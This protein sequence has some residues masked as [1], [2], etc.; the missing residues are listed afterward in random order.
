M[1]T[2]TAAMIMKWPPENRIGRTS[3]VT[4]IGTFMEPPST[5]RLSPKSPGRP[6]SIPANTWASPTVASVRMSRGTVKNRR[7]TSR[8]TAAPSRAAKARPAP[9]EAQ[10]DQCR[11]LA[12]S[13]V[14]VAAAEPMATWAKLMTRAAR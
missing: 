3:W 13:S 4:R 8:S 2:G 11:M 7:I 6:S 12:S 9:A 1:T 5:L 14:T 10:Y